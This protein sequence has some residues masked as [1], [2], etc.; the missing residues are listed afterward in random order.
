MEDS[1]LIAR[2]YPAD[3]VGYALDMIQGHPR[4]IK[5]AQQ[6][7][8]D[9]Q[10]RTSRESTVEYQEFDDDVA[11]PYLELRFSHVP[12]TSLGLI[13][14]RS[15]SSDIVLPSLAKI[16][17]SHFALTYKNTF[18][19][20]HYRLVVR[21][22]GSTRGTTVSYDGK[23]DELRKGFDWIASGFEVPVSVESLIIQPHKY[24]SFRLVVIHHDIA[25]PAYI[26][27]VKRF[28]N[29]GTAA[30]NF[31]G[32]LG[33]QPYPDMERT[34]GANTRLSNPIL[35]QQDPSVER[36]QWGGVPL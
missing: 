20:G 2:L 18:A 21:D 19:D 4:C 12:R 15:A 8:L 9:S 27:N 6:P 35:I 7:E 16:S 5:G 34:T 31:L 11:L 25:S 24:L 30:D 3:A 32:G 33:L 14:G 1:D 17:S 29:V 36:Q 22:L 28:C 13:F 26:D 10:S 23:G